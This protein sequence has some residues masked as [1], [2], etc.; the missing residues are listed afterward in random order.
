MDKRN[1]TSEVVKKT[2]NKIE[3]TKVDRES[4]PKNNNKIERQ[5]GRNQSSGDERTYTSW[6]EVTVIMSSLV[7]KQRQQVVAV[8]DKNSADN[9]QQQQ[10]ANKKV[11]PPNKGLS[12]RSVSFEKFLV[13]A[14]HIR[15][16]CKYT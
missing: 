13:T 12:R 3:W 1:E 4:A 14:F 2:S 11:I 15:L 7:H 8:D 16:A 10:A 9:S 6:S 5:F